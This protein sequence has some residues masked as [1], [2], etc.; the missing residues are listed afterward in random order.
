MRDEWFI[1]GAVPMTKSEVRAVS[2]SKLELSDSAVLWDVGA[3]TG[4]VSVEAALLYSG[5]EVVAFEH[6]GEAIGLIEENRKKA[7][8]DRISVVKGMAPDSFQR[9]LELNGKNAS[10]THAF[11]GGSSGRME[12]ILKSLWLLNPSIRVVINV[13]ALESLAEVLRILKKR[14]TEAEVVSVQVSRAE[15]AGNSHLMKGQNPV[16]IIAFGG[17]E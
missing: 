6:R 4:S 15:K 10:P 5:L 9:A 16:Y 12:E 13:I 8:T 11:I 3:G 17:E 2:I 14:E 1:R 7:G